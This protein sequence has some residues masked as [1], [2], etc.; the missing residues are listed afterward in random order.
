MSRSRL[1]SASLADSARFVAG[2]LI[3]SAS[4]GLF[5]PRKPVIKL[6]V[7][8]DADRRVGELMASLRKK[9]GGAGLRLLGG[10]LVTLWGPDEIREVLDRSAVEYDS[11]GGAKG[12]GMSHF[13]PDALTLSSGD[14]WRDRRAFNEHVLATSERIHPDAARIVGVVLDEVDK[15]GR[16][17]SLEWEHWEQLFDHTTLRVIFGDGAREDQELT[18][19]LETLMSQANRIAGL[20]H[21]DDYYELYGRLE[22]K[23]RDPEEGSLLARVASAPQSDVTRVAHQIPHWMFAMRDTLG[24]NAYRALALLAADAGLQERARSEIGG[25]DLSDPAVVDGLSLVEGVLQEAMRLWPTTPL[26]ARETKCPVHLAGEQLD[27]GTQVMILNTFNHRDT[28]SI[29]D[30][31]RLVPE[32]WTDGRERDPRF[33]HLSGGSQYCPGIPLVLL[34]GKACLGRWVER[35]DLTLEEPSGLDPSGDL[36]RMLDFFAIRLSLKA[37]EPAESFERSQSSSQAVTSPAS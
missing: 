16:P 5:A 20:K 29:P 17:K 15:L 12:K 26:L 23:L 35:H 32:R 14:E 10:R 21:G 6:L 9:Y 2:A 24:A 1:P 28:E 22:R 8:R 33:N 4:R 19:L 31:D 37:R 34:I 27:E 30:A 7:R 36:P 3:P 11:G 18:E 25:R 13:Q